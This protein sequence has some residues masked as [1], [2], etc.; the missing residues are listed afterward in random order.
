MDFEIE[1]TMEKVADDDN[2]NIKL[3]LAVT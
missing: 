3:H 2:S 1:V